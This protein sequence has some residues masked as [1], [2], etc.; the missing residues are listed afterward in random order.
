MTLVDL[1]KGECQTFVDEF[2]CRN[3]YRLLSQRCYLIF[4]SIMGSRFLQNIQSKS[5]NTT[6]QVFAIMLTFLSALEIPFW[7]SVGMFN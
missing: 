2:F 4:F 3:N 7:G 1:L 6:F 5:F